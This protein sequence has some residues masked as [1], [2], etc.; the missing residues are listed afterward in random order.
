MQARYR[1]AR[2]RPTG[3]GQLDFDGD[4][5]RDDALAD[6]DVNGIAGRNGQWEL[7]LGD[8]DGT[9]DAASAPKPET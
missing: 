8:T 6:L 1:S 4:G 9:P 3:H 7:K 5:L 2:E